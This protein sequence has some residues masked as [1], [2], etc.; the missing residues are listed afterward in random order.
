MTQT[1]THTHIRT[2]RKAICFCF[3]QNKNP[4]PKKNTELKAIS[5]GHQPRLQRLSK[6][7]NFE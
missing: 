7:L 6:W 4:Q 3:L 2:L 1:H 5:F